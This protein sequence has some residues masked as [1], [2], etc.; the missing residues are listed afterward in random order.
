MLQNE[1]RSVSSEL[2]EEKTKNQTY[3]K[4]REYTDNE[5][6]T[7][8]E[9]LAVK[10]SENEREIRGREN[11][12][13]QLRQLIEAN[14][15]KDIEIKNKSDELKSHKEILSKTEVQLQGEQGRCDKIENERDAV[16]SQHIRLQ[17]DFQSQEAKNL[18][19]SNK[20]MEQTRKLKTYQ[21]EIA[22][23]RENYKTISK[24]KQALTKKYKL[25]DEVKVSAEMERD[26]LRV[27][28]NLI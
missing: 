23:L 12:E 21:E 24:A 6:L 14:E 26:G 27:L 19:L 10:K 18:V 7:L 15:K 4:E 20:T 5:M 22:R 17:N 2:E 9:Y 25:L 28:I 8:K 13:N 1:L 16:Y 3:L 11:A